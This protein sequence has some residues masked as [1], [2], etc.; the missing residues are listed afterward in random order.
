[1]PLFTAA[2]HGSHRAAGA[3]PATTRYPHTL[4]P[5]TGVAG[6]AR[7]MPQS[8]PVWIVQGAVP[9]GALV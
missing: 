8:A 1:M 3:Y 4:H 2:L 5:Y 9:F 7:G 6:P